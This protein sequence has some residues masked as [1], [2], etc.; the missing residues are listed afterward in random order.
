MTNVEI[1]NYLMTSKIGK[2]KQWHNELQNQVES[3][4]TTAGKIWGETATKLMFTE[5]KAKMG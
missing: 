3:Y 4:L 1:P 2:L 5:L